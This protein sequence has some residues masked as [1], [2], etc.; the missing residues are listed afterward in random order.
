MFSIR[1]MI[2]LVLVT[3]MV[4]IAP[5][6][7]QEETPVPQEIV[8]YCQANP[9]ESVNSPSGP[10]PCSDVIEMVDDEAVPLA[11]RESE[12]D[13]SDNSFNAVLDR[14]EWEQV[15]V[16]NPLHTEYVLVGENVFEFIKLAEMQ[17]S[18]QNNRILGIEA[19]QPAGGA[20]G[21]TWCVPAQADCT[22]H[23]VIW[24]F[25]FASGE[26][27]EGSM[28]EIAHRFRIAAEDGTLVRIQATFNPEYTTAELTE[29]YR[30]LNNGN[31]AIM[32]S[33]D[34]PIPNADFTLYKEDLAEPLSVGFSCWYS[35]ADTTGQVF[36]ANALTSEEIEHI[37]PSTPCPESEL[38][39]FSFQIPSP[40]DQPE[41]SF[42]VIVEVDTMGLLS[43]EVIIW[44]GEFIPELQPVEAL[45]AG[46]G[47]IESIAT[48][49]TTSALNFRTQPAMNSSVITVIP[50]GSQ[51]DVIEYSADEAWAKVFFGGREGWVHTSLIISAEG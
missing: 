23:L 50:E 37:G 36:D 48:V 14:F 19:N 41:W 39:G 5:V 42:D 22:N 8:D 49:I 9:T 31:P 12:I 34:R 7:A 3:M 10:M 35:L 28:M 18:I 16:G 46:G 47:G 27:L 33:V 17:T 20:D 40:E 4:L 51:L 2:V 25:S 29:M 26:I 1:N 44:I 43:R 6:A 21:E 30:N 45:G 13:L 11:E 32:I 15:L 24:R 38:D